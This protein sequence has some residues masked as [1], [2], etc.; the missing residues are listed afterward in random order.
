VLTEIYLCLACSCHGRCRLASGPFWLRFTYAT[1]VLVTPLRME[2]PGQTM[3]T[4]C[5]PAHRPP[6]GQRRRAVS[7]SRRRCRAAAAAAWWARR[8]RR[9]R[10]RSCGCF[11][12]RRAGLAAAA[13]AACARHAAPRTTTSTPSP[14]RWAAPLLEPLSDR[15]QSCAGGGVPWAGVGAL[16]DGHGCVVQQ[17]G[18]GC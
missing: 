12:C 5:R 9:G 16:C 18:L 4:C 10:R 3:A 15:S 17:A 2:T 1:P 7:P 6:R 14:G 11:R 13:A 8:F